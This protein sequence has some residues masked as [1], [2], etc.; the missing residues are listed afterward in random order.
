[1]SEPKPTR[2]LK[3]IKKNL[4]AEQERVAKAV[5]QIEGM[6]VLEEDDDEDFL[7]LDERANLIANEA[8]RQKRVEM[9]NRAHALNVKK[10]IM[11]SLEKGE[12][13]EVDQKQLKELG[14]TD[15]YAKQ[16]GE[17]EWIA[18]L[19]NS[20]LGHALFDED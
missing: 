18:V 10:A 11:K 5:P 8:I 1:M 3:E 12:K 7:D 6:T 4:R 13:P 9:Q 17:H 19:M 2:S 20:R 15:W 16:L 14:L